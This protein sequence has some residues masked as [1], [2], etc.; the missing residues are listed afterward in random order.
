MLYFLTNIVTLQL[1]KLI[2]TMNPMCHRHN[3]S[4]NKRN[5]HLMSTQRYPHEEAKVTP[6]PLFSCTMGSQLWG[7]FR[8]LS[9]VPP[10]ISLMCF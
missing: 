4:W 10:A 1:N 7:V 2:S 8:C 3:Q 6:L 5:E 9:S